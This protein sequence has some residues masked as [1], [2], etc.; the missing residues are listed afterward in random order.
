MDRQEPWFWEDRV[1]Y[2]EFVVACEISNR[3]AVAALVRRLSELSGVKH[4]PLIGEMSHKE[5][6]DLVWE[7]ARGPSKRLR[8]G[9]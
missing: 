3:G 7:Y 6:I 8:S 5:I 2:D 9:K 1:P 4:E